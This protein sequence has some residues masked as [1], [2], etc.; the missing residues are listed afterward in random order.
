MELLIKTHKINIVVKDA[1]VDEC[2]QLINEGVVNILDINKAEIKAKIDNKVE[3]IKLQIAVTEEKEPKTIKSTKSTKKPEAVPF[4]QAKDRKLTFMICPDCGKV[5]YKVINITESNYHSCSCGAEVFIDVDTLV[6]G[7][8]DCEECKSYG[9]FLMHPDVNK[10]KCK[11]CS[12]TFFMIQDL[13]TG[14][15]VGKKF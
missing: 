15:Y 10:I 4:K 3:D 6:E 12:E 9:N 1:T 11:G 2:V 14:K 13:E 8:Y 5:F 7:T